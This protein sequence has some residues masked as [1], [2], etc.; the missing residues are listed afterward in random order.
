MTDPD[1]KA[2]TVALEYYRDNH[3]GYRL[4]GS[5]DAYIKI[6]HGD[7]AK[8]ALQ[9]LSRIEGRLAQSGTAGKPGEGTE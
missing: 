4:R 3:R 5:D 9:A 6:D 2:V 1:L 8:E 7:K